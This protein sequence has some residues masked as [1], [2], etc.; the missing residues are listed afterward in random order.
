MSSRRLVSRGRANQD[1]SPAQHPRHR[2]SGAAQE[3]TPLP[4]YEPPSCALTPA[5]KC[6][7]ETLSAS[8]DYSKYKRHLDGSIKAITNSI[9]D[10]NERLKL[11]KEDVAKAANRRRQA[12]E[13]E[14]KSEED[15]ARE[16]YA[17]GMEKKV[18]AL[19][20]KAEM[21]LR[22]LIDY[23]DELAMRD[24]M[25]KEVSENIAAAPAPRPAARRQRRQG[26][27]EDEDSENEEEVEEDEELEVDGCI[28]SAVELLKK[29]QRE[30]AATYASKSLRSRY[31][32]HS[33]NFDFKR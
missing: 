29:A 27:N 24:T 16:Q 12:E 19:T 11:R 15:I 28:V 8:H 31:G 25:M 23:G 1:S 9:G 13:G 14:E 5:A 2:E 6:A 32:A 17:D 21:S 33:T 18:E 22:D 7:L 26:S 10:S 20:T 3:L 30:Y 4:P